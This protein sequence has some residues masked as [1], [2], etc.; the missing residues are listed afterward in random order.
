MDKVDRIITQLRT[1]QQEEALSGYRE[2]L[3]GGSAAE[4]FALYEGMFELGFLNEAASLIE[5]LLE[6]YPGDGEL[7]TSL[8]EIYIELG[9]DEKALL[10]LN[11]IGEDD[12]SYPKSLLI[13]ADL[14]QMQGLYEVSEQKLLQAK[15]LLPDEEVIDFALG[16]LYLE[17]G[18]FTEAIQAYKRV[19]PE[20]SMGGANIYQRL[21][22]A[23]SAGGAFEEALPYYDQ[24]LEKQLDP[25]TLFHYG[26]TAYQAGKNALAIRKFTDLKELDPDYFSLYYYLAKAYEKE[27]EL[28]K[29]FQTIKD[30]IHYDEF[31]KDLFFLGGKIALKLGK[32][33]EGE[34]YLKKALE[35]DPEFIEAGLVLNK[36]LLHQE[37]YEDV[38]ENCKSFMENGLEDPQFF[39]DEA[40]ALQNLEL[41]LE[42]LNKYELAY[43]FFKDNIDFLVD[44]GYFLI[45]EGKREKAAEIFNILLEKDPGNFEFQ[46]LVER[47]TD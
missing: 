22:E 33:E 30:G 32:E 44:Y 40:V 19:L 17:E 7:L 37:K 27:E 15:K 1:G 6:Q 4:K 38:L 26:F 9:D 24:A 16:E 20:E 47:L 43:N 35:L 14:Y 23:Y 13:Q 39:W 10:I 41:Y 29:S 5:N 3:T 46:Q 18:R 12:P 8:G 36:I 2:I 42:A 31:N 45:E 28:E 25:D 11:Q 21:A 34:A